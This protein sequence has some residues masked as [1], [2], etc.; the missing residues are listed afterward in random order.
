VKEARKSL[1]KESEEILRLRNRLL[2]GE[3][4]VDDYFS[5]RLRLESIYMEKVEEGL[6]ALTTRRRSGGRST[7]PVSEA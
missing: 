6:R 4:S 7:T 5:E 3:I 1:S 2:R